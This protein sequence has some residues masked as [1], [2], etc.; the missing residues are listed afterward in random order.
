MYVVQRNKTSPS[1]VKVKLVKSSSNFTEDYESVKAIS[2]TGCIFCRK[3]V[4]LN[5]TTFKIFSIFQCMVAIRCFF[6]SHQ[7]NIYQTVVWFIQFQPYKTLYC[8][9]SAYHPM[10]RTVGSTQNNCARDCWNHLFFFLV[11]KYDAI[12]NMYGA[13]CC[14]KALMF[15]QN[16]YHI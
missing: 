6:F 5:M 9:S 7:D 14:H 1:E 12:K 16:M 8:K 3:N 11:R 4:F 13:L 15:T 10:L 2:K